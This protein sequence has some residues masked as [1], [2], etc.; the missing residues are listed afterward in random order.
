MADQQT[1]ESGI[2]TLEL[3]WITRDPELQVRGKELNEDAVGQYADQM[4]AGVEFPPVV[5]FF[6]GRE[7]TYWLAEGFHR[8]AAAEAAALTTIVAEVRLGSRQDARDA[9][10]A[11]NKEFD[12][13][14]QRRTRADKKRAVNMMLEDHPDWSDR[15]VATHVGVD[16]STVWRSRRLL[17]C[18]N[19]PD[20]PTGSDPVQ[21]TRPVKTPPVSPPAPP[22]GD[23]GVDHSNI[24]ET[25]DL[26]DNVNEVA[27]DR[28]D[29][30]INLN[31]DPPPPVT[32]GP[33]NRHPPVTVATPAQ[34]K[35][36]PPAVPP[37]PPPASPA[38]TPTPTR[39]SGHTPAQMAEA[40]RAKATPDFVLDL[41]W[42]L[43]GDDVVKIVQRLVYAK[44]IAVAVGGEY[45]YSADF[46]SCV[47]P[48]DPDLV[49]EALQVVFHP[50][51]LQRLADRILA[52]VGDEGG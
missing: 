16:P 12:V 21:D 39:V 32:P 27:V 48:L 15:R 51:D 40:I 17:H 47:V 31:P 43:T 2:Y 23:I 9:A 11:S 22:E 7:Q 14:G 20:C 33:V 36:T 10:A 8:C 49:F 30:H 44:V 6:D 24:A 18:N 19:S 50:D 25:P 28:P 26:V 41:I 38:A 46:P 37:P 45:V 35:A 1:M 52:A 34:P 4:L 3:S 42:E 29:D 5:V 13:V